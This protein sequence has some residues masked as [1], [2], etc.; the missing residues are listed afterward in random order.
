M[1]DVVQAVDGP[2]GEN[3]CMLDEERGGQ[4]DRCP[5]HEV[6][7]RGQDAML[8][9]LAGKSVAELGQELVAH[10]RRR[11]RRERSKAASR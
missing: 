7:R 4:D 3:G 11:R 5:L 1:L 6:W 2:F 8:A 9:E 10:A